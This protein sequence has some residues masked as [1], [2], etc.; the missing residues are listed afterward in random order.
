[1]FSHCWVHPVGWVS[2][3]HSV[4]LCATLAAG[5]TPLS[6]V[7]IYFKKL[8]RTIMFSWVWAVASSLSDVAPAVQCEQRCWKSWAVRQSHKSVIIEL[9]CRNLWVIYIVWHLEC[10]SQNLINYKMCLLEYSWKLWSHIRSEAGLLQV[11]SVFL[12]FCFFHLVI[13]FTLEQFCT[14]YIWI[15]VIKYRFIKTK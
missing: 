15:T 3:H 13:V 8:Q 2:Y 10:N 11:F 6:C 7:S 5:F 1:M 9:Y 12:F 4:Y 14:D